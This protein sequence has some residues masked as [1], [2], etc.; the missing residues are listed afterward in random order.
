MGRKMALL[1]AKFNH[2]NRVLVDGRLPIINGTIFAGRGASDV[3]P[4]SLRCIVYQQTSSSVSK[5]TAVRRRGSRSSLQQL[6]T[7]SEVSTSYVCYPV[8]DQLVSTGN[9]IVKL[10]RR[11][12]RLYSVILKCYQAGWPNFI[13]PTDRIQKQPTLRQIGENS[14]AF[15]LPGGLFACFWLPFAILIDFW[16][17]S[18]S[19]S[20]FVIIV[21]IIIIRILWRQSTGF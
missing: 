19:P 17:G 20:V 7:L 2:S 14:W 1:F 12:R 18:I 16:H 13:Y 6:N 15:I 3:R 21:M 11:N 8:Y 5:W 10:G 9:N 4:Q